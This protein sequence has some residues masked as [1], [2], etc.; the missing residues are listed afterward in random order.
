[1]YLHR[2]LP[3]K[4]GMG[5]TVNGIPVDVHP[6][7]IKVRIPNPGRIVRVVSG[8]ITDLR[9]A[10]YDQQESTLALLLVVA[11]IPIVV[12]FAQ[13]WHTTYPHH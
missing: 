11:A 9:S 12:A 10:S 1:M 8:Y 4:K 2:R 5:A 7:A 6:R 3:Y 13:W